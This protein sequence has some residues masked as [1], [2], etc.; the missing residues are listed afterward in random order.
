MQSSPS[1]TKKHDGKGHVSSS[2]AVTEAKKTPV[3]VRKPKPPHPLVSLLGDVLVNAKGNVIS[4]QALAVEDSVIGLYFAAHWCPPCRS[5]CP[6]L[7]LLYDELKE[8]NESFEVVLI[9]LDTKENSYAEYLSKMPWWAVPF[10]EEDKREEI[11]IT[12]GIKGIPVLV[13]LDPNTLEIIAHNGRDI[14]SLD[15]RGAYFPWKDLP[16]EI[17]RTSITASSKASSKAASSKKSIDHRRA[18]SAD[19]PQKRNSAGLD[20]MKQPVSAR[21]PK[22]QGGTSAN[23]AVEK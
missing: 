17:T 21:S 9:S 2:K 23:S 15:P 19:R 1:K 20:L 8:R 11:A 13:L 22:P 14:I 7:M 3:S 10:L 4:P 16:E 6:V 18:V 12:F 5:F